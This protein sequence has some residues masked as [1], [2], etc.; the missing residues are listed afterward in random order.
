M[1]LLVEFTKAYITPSDINEHIETLRRYA[2]NCSSVA[3]FGVRGG[4]STCGLLYG[5]SQSTSPQKSYIGVDINDCEITGRMSNLATQSDIKYNF[6]KADSAIADIEPVDLLFIDSWH[7]Y[8]HLKRELA[9]NHT[10]VAKHI[11]MHDTTVDE[12]YGESLRCG[13][14]TKQQSIK[15]GYSEDEIR[16]GLWPAISEFLHDHP[17]WELEKKY[18]NCNG[19]TILSRKP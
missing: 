14:D 18:T 5:L 6:I 9:K 15:S 1:E 3:E 8:G 13:W 19:L 7:V 16:K 11:I 10:K 17:E 12:F 4:V 2:S